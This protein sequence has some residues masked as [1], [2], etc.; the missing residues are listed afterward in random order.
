MISDLVDLDVVLELLVHVDLSTA[1]VEA[2]IEHNSLLFSLN[3]H[4]ADDSRREA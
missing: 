4:E 1:R 3:V 2:C